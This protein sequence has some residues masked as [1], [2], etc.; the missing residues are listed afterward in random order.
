MRFFYLAHYDLP[1]KTV[2]HVIVAESE[3]EAREFAGDKVD[4]VERISLVKKGVVG[5]E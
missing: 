1:G 3:E 4:R 2:T 5:D